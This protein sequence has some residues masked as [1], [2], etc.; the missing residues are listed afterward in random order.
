MTKF[1]LDSDHAGPVTIAIDQVN[2]RFVDETM[3]GTY[4][5]PPIK[6]MLTR[7]RNDTD[8]TTEVVTKR[9]VY[10]SGSREADTHV[11]L[12]IDGGLKAGEYILVY[13]G[14]FTELNTERKLVVSVYCGQ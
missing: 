3:R 2:A 1:T 6:L 8:P 5:Y 4:E 7:V 11:S 13:Q 10:L 14:E 9:Q 12:A